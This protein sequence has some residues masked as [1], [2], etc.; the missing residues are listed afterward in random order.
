MSKEFVLNTIIG[1]GSSVVGNVETRGFTRVDGSLLGNLH[2][3]GRIIISEKARMKS[4]V[5]GTTIT[6]G[7]VVYG[8]VIASERL[9][10][11]ASGL[12][13]GDIITRRIQAD[14]GCMIHGKVA[15]CA[16]NEEWD[17]TIAK[18][19]DAKGIHLALSSLKESK[20]WKK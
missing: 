4:D 17:A 2:S 10:V 11:L 5:S 12:V 9:I 19:Q 13:M 15:V 16:T 14:D 3:K 8:N 7:G 1:D 6:I 18:Y 20:K